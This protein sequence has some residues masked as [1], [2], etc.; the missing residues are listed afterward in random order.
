MKVGRSALDE[1]AIR[2]IEESHPN[3]EF[4][5]TRIL[6]GAESESKPLVPFGERRKAPRGQAPQGERAPQRS[7]R[8]APVPLQTPESVPPIVRA[9]VEAP[10]AESALVEMTTVDDQI[11][12][13]DESE[14]LLTDDVPLIPEASG[15]DEHAPVTAAHARL[16]AEGVMRLRA[17]YS[18]VL[19][20]IS[21]RVADPARQDQLKAEAE[22]LNPDTW[23]TDDE[24]R[25]GL[26]GYE[27]IFESLRSVVARRR[28]RRR[29][30]GPAGTQDA[31]GSNAD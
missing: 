4:D 15:T 1:D 27:T 16:G 30:R 31:A 21:E 18:E 2:L 25:A 28:R 17:R 29:G 11:P 8:P 9:S 10:T 22:R 26:E 24:V 23:A 12:S 3:V 19:A 6:K 14:P 7:R 13:L 5:W 20:R